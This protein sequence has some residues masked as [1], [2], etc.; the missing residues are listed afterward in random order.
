MSRRRRRPARVV[1][2][3][4]T[5]VTVVLL[6][7]TGCTVKEPDPADWRELAA[8]TLDDVA[9]E[10]ATAELTL[11]QLDKGNLPAAYGETVL[12]EAEKAA[13]TAEETLSSVQAPRGLRGRADQVLTLIGRA[14]D[15]VQAAREAAVAGQ[16]HV[17]GLVRKLTELRAALD[18]RR[19]RL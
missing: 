9:S 7:S 17:P 16:F 4:V 11:T 12:A 13:G 14:V 8:Q 1:V 5:A 19:S 18:E 10:V 3:A 6:A 15:A 2:T